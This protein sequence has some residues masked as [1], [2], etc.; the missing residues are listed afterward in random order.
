M[1]VLVG[2]WTLGQR[3]TMGT[4][5][6]YSDSRVFCRLH[7]FRPTCFR[8]AVGPPGNEAEAKASFRQKDYI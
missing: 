8:L 7:G 1:E 6:F 4:L 5:I 2:N 3:G